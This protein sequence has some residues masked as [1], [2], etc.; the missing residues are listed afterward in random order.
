MATGWERTGSWPW[1]GNPP[2]QEIREDI[3]RTLSL[4]K[5]L[6]R[7]VTPEPLS[8]WR[9]AGFSNEPVSFFSA[10]PLKGPSRRQR[11]TG[12]GCRPLVVMR[13]A[14]LIVAR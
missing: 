10:S 5:P 3:S 7:G 12:E 9:T 13:L 1:F 8:D 6:L 14:Q 2:K 11:G 4:E